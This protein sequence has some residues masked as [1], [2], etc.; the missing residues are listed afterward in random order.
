MQ[1]LILSLRRVL[2]AVLLFL[3][4][5]T[6]WG[7]RVIALSF[8]REVAEDDPYAIRGEDTTTEEV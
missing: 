1:D 7:R 6:P 5:I 8:L 2:I 4:L 3:M